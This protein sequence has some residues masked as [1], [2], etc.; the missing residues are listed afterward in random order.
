MSIIT[1]VSTDPEC[2]KVYRKIALRLIPFLFV[3]YVLAFLDRINVGFAQLHMKQDIGLSD[4]AYGLGAGILF[5]GYVLFEV[6]SNIYMQRVGA[7]KTIARIMFFWGLTSAAML[8]V[9]TPTQFYILRFL[10]G[11]FEAGLLPGVLMYLTYW[12]PKRMHGRV[13]GRFMTA[14]VVAG[15]IGGPI[16]GAILSHPPQLFGLAGWQWMFLLEGL[17]SSILGVTT[18]FYLTDRPSQAAWLTDSEKQMVQADLEEQETS[19]IGHSSAGWHFALKDVK[20][21]ILAICFFTVQCG[22]YAGLFWM[23]I[24]IRETG[25]TSAVDIG[26]YSMIP[27]G[28]AIAA[29]LFW[30]THSDRKL[31]RRWHFASTVYMAA[32]GFAILAM[33][34]GHLAGSLLGLTIATAAVSASY[35]VFWSIVPAYLPPVAVGFGFA[36]INSVGA[37]GGFFSPSLIGYI[38]NES[39]NVTYALYPI[40]AMLIAGATMLLFVMRQQNQGLTP[41]ESAVRTRA[42]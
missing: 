6:P 35:P 7:R 15:L 40:I 1:L 24:I 22:G 8:L 33:S 28:I 34:R 37:M 11:V 38:K 39:G 13:I 23:P 25:V 41:R 4:A 5:V 27:Y 21:Y 9:K 42:V 18:W 10:L 14:I 30:G 2:D 32:A 20:T 19:Q 3:C 16:S 17:P 29:M 26:I 36:F 12:F 31:E